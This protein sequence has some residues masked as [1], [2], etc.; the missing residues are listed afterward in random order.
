MA[1]QLLGEV[2]AMNITEQ[3]WK[4]FRKNLPLW[5]ESY[6]E[7]LN[8]EYVNI[9]CSEKSP[10][11][12]FWILEK[13]IRQDKKSRGVVMELRRQTVI[14]DLAALIMEGIISYADMADFSATLQE[15]VKYICSC[16]N[17]TER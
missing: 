1:L 4:I 7:K 8:N 13:R 9:L 16:L 12:K 3:D 14:Y 6:M 10:A 5:Q 15:N 17:G 2:T 11:E